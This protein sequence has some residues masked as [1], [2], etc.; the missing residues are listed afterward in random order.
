M[1]IFISQKKRRAPFWWRKP[2]INFEK[3]IK[4]KKFNDWWGTPAHHQVL[5]TI[6]FLCM[7]SLNKFLHFFWEIEIISID[8]FSSGVLDVHVKDP[9][10]MFLELIHLYFVGGLNNKLKPNLH[11]TCFHLD[12]FNKSW[13][14]LFRP[15]QYL[16]RP[17]KNTKI[18]FIRLPVDKYR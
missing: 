16:F 10:W 6:Y 11:G 1:I 15:P 4:I 3:K 12:N 14:L 7:I 2:K 18:T 17:P 13:R 9:W 5:F 8:T